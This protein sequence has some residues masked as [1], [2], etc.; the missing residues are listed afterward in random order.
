MYHATRRAMMTYA[1]AWLRGNIYLIFWQLSIA[2]AG[3]LASFIALSISGFRPRPLR[4]ASM[5]SKLSL[6]S[7][8]LLIKKFMISSRVQK[9]SAS[10]AVPLITRSRALPSQTSVPWLRPEMRISSSS[11]LG[12]VSVSIPCTNAVPN[13]GTP[14]VPVGLSKS[15]GLTPM[16]FCAQKQPHHAGVDQRQGAAGHARDLL[17]VVQHGRVDM[18]QAVQLH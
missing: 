14:S 10:F 12:W 1:T 13:S 6:K 11:V 9:H 7:M 15:S 17:Q 16:V 5:M 18:A 8:P 4:T 3:M 2:Q